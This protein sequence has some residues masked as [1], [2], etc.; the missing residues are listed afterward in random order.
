MEEIQK[1]LRNYS[2]AE[3]Y[4]KDDD[5]LT[6]L[7]QWERQPDR[8]GTAA[9]P[10]I[11]AG[12]TLVD[13]PIGLAE[14]GWNVGK[15]VAD[16]FGDPEYDKFP[17]P[18]RESGEDLYQDMS[19]EG[20]NIATGL[21]LAGGFAGGAALGATKAG[22]LLF[23]QPL[24]N[25]IYNTASKYFTNVNT[26]SQILNS[27]VQ[28]TSKFLARGTA[29]A[30]ANLVADTGFNVAEATDEEGNFHADKF[31]HDE[32]MSAAFGL[33]VGGGL[34]MLDKG[35]VA[36]PKEMSED[37]MKVASRR[38]R[39]AIIKGNQ[40]EKNL[41][42]KAVEASNQKVV[43]AEARQEPLNEYDAYTETLNKQEITPDDL[44][45]VDEFEQVK[46]NYEQ[47][48]AEVEEFKGDDPKKK[49]DFGIRKTYEANQQPIFSAFEKITPK[50][51]Q[52]IQRFRVNSKL[53][54]AARLA[55]LR[56]M[57]KL[58]D[59]D[60]LFGNPFR[61]LGEKLQNRGLTDMEVF[62]L[63]LGKNDYDS[64]KLALSRQK[65]ADE[66]LKSFDEVVD[67]Y[68]LIGDEAVEL[69]I[70]K[71]EALRENYWARW[72][73]DPEKFQKEIFKK[74]D[75][76]DRVEYNSAV[77]E[78]EVKE[79]RMFNPREK[80]Q[81]LD[82]FVRERAASP[83]ASNTKQRKID[84]L[85]L[86]MLKY[87]HDP[88]TAAQHYMTDMTRQ[89]E[90]ARLLRLKDP[91]FEPTLQLEEQ[92]MSALREGGFEGTEDQLRIE[93][94]RTVYKQNMIKD[95]DKVITEQMIDDK[96]KDLQKEMREQGKYPDIDINDVT[97]LKQVATD[98]LKDN[99][100]SNVIDL[101]RRYLQESGDLVNENALEFQT[102]MRNA[103]IDSKKPRPA[104]Q[105]ELS[106]FTYGVL[107]GNPMAA[108]TQVKDIVPIAS[109]YGV[110]RSLK[111]YGKALFNMLPNTPDGKMFTLNDA[112][113]DDLYN[114]TLDADPKA[115]NL[116]LDIVLKP[117][118]LVDE[119]GGTTNLESSFRYWKEHINTEKGLNKFVKRFGNY[120]RKDELES[121]VRALRENNGLDDQ[122]NMHW[123]VK[124]VMV[125]ETMDMRPSDIFDKPKNY[126]N[127]PE[128]RIA[129]DLLNFSIKRRDFL[130]R[131]VDKIR[132]SGKN[133]PEKALEFTGKT[134]SFLALT[135][136]A[137][138]AVEGAKD[139][140]SFRKSDEITFMDAT[141]N[142]ALDSV[143]LNQIPYLMGNKRYGYK[144]KD[145]KF[146]VYNRKDLLANIGNMVAPTSWLSPAASVGSD[147]VF[148]G[149]DLLDTKSGWTL[150]R[151]TRY[152]PIGGPSFYNAF[153]RT[154]RENKAA[155][156]ARKTTRP[157][158]RRR[159]IRRRRR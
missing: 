30:T 118:K 26:G 50:F 134:A 74:L 49:I 151:S 129:Y 113:L 99:S 56:T 89:I 153:K 47:E 55:P 102:L 54:T 131:Q 58:L 91:T 12:K 132:K 130:Y 90:E 97:T 85:Q 77:H 142:A 22:Q 120:F 65:N 81:F 88:L 61:K 42:V 117:L 150:P 3:V 9:A 72:V 103:F 124:S 28:G 43:E 140:V 86:K 46:N 104:F 133:N 16:P 29:A 79:G 37:F 2:L 67:S 59:G 69:G 31:W 35:T 71:P 4:K 75:D 138:V 126:L 11:G 73:K 51:S 105:R 137:N 139:V 15:N 83:R 143:G 1:L 82:S 45:S 119:A 98:V 112:G 157:K 48:V 23:A 147:I 128:K 144:T 13:L 93:A 76:V 25:A 10:I 156:T 52:H 115:S 57:K 39:D 145:G 34:S 146:K 27:A 84:Q 68:R 62:S 80:A 6:A 122:G 53:K 114:Y 123:G 148:D 116:F 111:A 109:R 40:I 127:N 24:E 63:A 125:H 21:E 106:K 101:K 121:T 152:V 7:E 87:Y 66:V 100:F 155:N 154:E 36:K 44:N 108:F 70:L 107:L 92:A 64:A 20:R 8:V 110:G 136:M 158:S 141:I 159:R 95:Y 149:L 17:R 96:V 14:F 41:E 5:D 18:F 135:L 78:A 38:T 60:K 33:A 19:P 32:T 94:R